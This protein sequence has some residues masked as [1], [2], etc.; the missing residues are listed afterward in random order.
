MANVFAFPTEYREGVPRALLEA[1]LV[2]LPLVATNMPGCDE[3]VHDR[4]SGRLV[5]PGAPHEMAAAIVDLLSD[6]AAAGAM[7]ARA[8]QT[9]RR[10][11][12]LASTVERYQE[13]YRRF[14]APSPPFALSSA[15]AT[16]DI[17][18]RSLSPS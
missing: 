2:G 18:S 1:A 12:G 8:A 9:V 15:G 5:K 7:G 6:P 10:Q 17:G 3:V 11:F 4:W 16:P 14:L 13:V